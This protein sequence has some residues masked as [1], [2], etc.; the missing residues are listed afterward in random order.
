MSSSAERL[1]NRLANK[2]VIASYNISFASDLGALI[3]SEKHFISRE[4]VPP[5]EEKEDAV[6]EDV[7]Y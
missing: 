5:E 3:G 4:D 2:L 6:T 1:A 7:S